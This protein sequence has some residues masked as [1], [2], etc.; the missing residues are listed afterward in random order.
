[1]KTRISL[2]FP[3]RVA[4]VAVLVLAACG[5][6]GH[7]QSAPT[8]VPTPEELAATL[9][10]PDDLAGDWSVRALADVADDPDA[11]TIDADVLASGVV[12]EEYRAMLPTVE[13]CDAAGNEARAA[14]AALRWQAFRPLEIAVDDPIE[15]PADRSGHMVFVQEFLTAGPAD[16][17]QATFDALRV[18][19]TACLGDIPAGDEGPGTAEAMAVPNVGDDRSG[20]LTIVEEEGGWA[21]WRLY[22]VMVRTGP[23]LMLLKIVDIRAG[24]DPYFSSTEIDQIVTTAVDQL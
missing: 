15:P 3:T 22:D 2:R 17:I 20:V 24:V 13:L 23:E 19:M 14:A 5:E 10:A 6:D 18:G 4:A 7:D 11:A 21:E 16:E 12:P 8:A 1:M 9:L